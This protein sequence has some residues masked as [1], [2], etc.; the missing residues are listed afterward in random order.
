MLL[1]LGFSVITAAVVAAL[2]RP[3]LRGTAAVLDPAAA[4]LAVY[5]D[6]LTE[7]TLDRERG[8][9]ADG[10][11]EAAR[12]EVARRLLAR[13]QALPGPR[14][15]RRGTGPAAGSA[16]GGDGSDR[17]ISRAAMF[18]GA[19]VPLLAIGL[20]L[21]FGSPRLPAQP[22]LARVSKP[23]ETAS[24]DELLAKVEARLR[25]NPEDGQGWDVIAPVYMVQQRPLDA[26]NAFARAISILGESPKRLAGLAEAHVLASNGMVVEPARLAYERLRVLEPGR[27][28]PK[29]WLAF[30][31]EQDGKLDAA[32]AEYRALLADAPPDA[33]WRP[34]VEERLQE[35]NSRGVG[36]GAPAAAAP[37]GSAPASSPPVASRPAAAA[38]GPRQEDIEAA[39]KMT[40]E[41]RAAMIEKMVEGLAA[42]LKVNGKDVAGWINL[43]RA[44]T[45]MG[46]RGDAQAALAEARGQLAGDNAA[47]AEIAALEKSLGL[48]S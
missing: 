25:A 37:V 16:A 48:G 18:V 28:E 12:T 33:P 9:I 24:I 4:D 39:S 31:K 1:W 6:Q 22:H 23:N 14:S 44:Y 8:L 34:M 35:V 41:Q 20:Y 26:A 42:K 5:R 45:V 19:L 2:L 27:L 32:A 38:A 17:S 36:G 7:I 3:L 29:F 46:R 43:V 10:E 47:L 11:A 13:E 15:A 40:A 21:Q 30:A